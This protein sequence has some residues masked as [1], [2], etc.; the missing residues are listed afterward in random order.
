MHRPYAAQPAVASRRAVW[1]PVRTVPRAGVQ[2][3]EQVVGEPPAVRA[4]LLEARVRRLDAYLEAAS[5]TRQG[6][7]ARYARSVGRFLAGATWSK[8]TRTRSTRSTQRAWEVTVARA[9][10]AR[11]EEPYVDSPSSLES[12]GTTDSGESE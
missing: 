11:S 6:L 2:R 9:E 7:R 5:P 4:A 10:S 8:E 12:G 3:R 1:P